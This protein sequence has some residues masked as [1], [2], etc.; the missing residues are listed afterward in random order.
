MAEPILKLIYCIL[1]PCCMCQ[2]DIYMWPLDLG[3]DSQSPKGDPPPSTLE[4]QY[5]CSISSFTYVL[6]NLA[7]DLSIPIP[8]HNS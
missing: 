5:C 2:Y 6:R 4:S 7:L 8:F 3:F 1:A